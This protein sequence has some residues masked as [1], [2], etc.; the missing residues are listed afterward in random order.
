MP[1]DVADLYQAQR[2]H[3]LV[4]EAHIAE[5]GFPWVVPLTTSNRHVLRHVKRQPYKQAKR[6]LGKGLNGVIAPISGTK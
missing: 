5:H 2:D 3:V 1:T 4:V 6:V